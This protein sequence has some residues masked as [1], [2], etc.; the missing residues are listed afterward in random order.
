MRCLSCHA[1]A[2]SRR[3]LALGPAAAASHRDA[4]RSP[5]GLDARALQLGVE[6]GLRGECFAA[7]VDA[8]RAHLQ[9][10]P[11]IHQ[12]G[13]GRELGVAVRVDESN[14]GGQRRGR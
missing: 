2:V 3:R 8:L 9:L 13:D 12:A 1:T 5:H 7:L 4:F 6:R 11:Q 14:R 10:L